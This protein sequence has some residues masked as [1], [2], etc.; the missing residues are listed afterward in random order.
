MT[1]QTGKDVMGL[2]TVSIGQEVYVGARSVL[3]G[4]H[5]PAKAVIRVGSVITP[6]TA[7]LA[8]TG[9]AAK[10]VIGVG[11]VITKTFLKK[12]SVFESLA[13]LG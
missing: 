6:E 12:Q 13:T 9:A 10:A 2:L 5:I 7:E 3:V 8:H 11:S 4:C 1:Y